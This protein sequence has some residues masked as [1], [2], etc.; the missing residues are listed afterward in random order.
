MHV[1]LTNRE[2]SSEVDCSTTYNGISSKFGCIFTIKAAAKSL[3]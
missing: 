2:E 1:W 3:Y